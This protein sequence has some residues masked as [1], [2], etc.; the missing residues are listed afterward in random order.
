MFLEG[1]WEQGWAL[2][3]RAAPA[4]GGWNKPTPLWGFTPI[5]GAGE[6]GR[7][8]GRTP[9]LMTEMGTARRYLKLASGSVI[10][11]L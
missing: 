6:L 9:L 7:C 10:D 3:S 8:V 2:R 5:R 11:A 4:L 1:F